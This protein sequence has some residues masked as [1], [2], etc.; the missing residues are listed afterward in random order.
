MINEIPGLVH[1]CNSWVVIRKS[2]GETAF[3]TT[4][5]KTVELVNFDKAVVMLTADWLCALNR[6]IAMNNA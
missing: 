1:N 6:A 3:E 5:R 4:S 2:T